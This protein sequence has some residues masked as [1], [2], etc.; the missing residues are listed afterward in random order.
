MFEAAL[1]A[2]AAYQDAAEQPAPR[3][4]HVTF[5]PPFPS[6]DSAGNLKL[7]TANKIV[8]CRFVARHTGVLAK[9]HF[10]VR[11]LIG[12][13]SSYTG[14]TLG[15][16]LCEI[17]RSLPDGQPDMSAAGLLD[18]ESFGPG[19]ARITNYCA[20]MNTDVALRRG[21][22]VFLCVS[23]S[24][25]A[26]ATNYAS[27]N[28]LYQNTSPLPGAQGRNERDPYAEDVYLS[29]DPRELVGGSIDGG[30]TFQLPGNTDAANTLIKH[31]FCHVQEYADGTKDGP[32]YYTA[33]GSSGNA[34]GAWVM[35]YRN[36]TEYWHATH[37]GAWFQATPGS[38]VVE[39]RVNGVTRATATLT[40]AGYGFEAVPLSADVYAK[41]GDTITISVT[42]DHTGAAGA[43]LY[44]VYSRSEWVALLGGA[45]AMDWEATT[46]P[47]AITGAYAGVALPVWLLPGKDAGQLQP[48]DVG[49]ATAPPGSI[50]V[51][52]PEYGATGDG[53]TNDYAAVA[54]AIAKCSADGGGL[55]WFP[56][57]TYLVG[58][59]LVVPTNVRLAGTGKNT[60]VLKKST[61]LTLLTFS[62]SSNSVRCQRG[63]AMDLRLDG[64]GFT[65]PL[66]NA[67]WADHMNF[68]RMWLYN[69]GAVGV[70]F[71]NVWDS[72]FSWSEFDTCSGIDG[73]N[74]SVLL[75]S[76]SDDS[77]NVIGFERCRWENFKDGALWISTAPI[78]SAYTMVTGSNPCYDVRL[79][80]CKMETPQ[81]RGL[82]FATS[83]D[84][85]DVHIDGMYAAARGLYSG[86]TTGRTLFSVIGASDMTF[87]RFRVRIDGV[88]NPSVDDVFTFNTSG[89]GFRLQD[90]FV[91][92][93]QLP[94]TG[95]VS[96]DGGT[97]EVFCE[98][99]RYKTGQ[100]GVIY[101]GSAG[102]IAQ[103]TVASHATAM[104][105]IRGPKVIN[106]S[107]TATITTIPVVPGG[108]EPVTLNFT[109]TASVTDGS[110]LKLNGNFT[111]PGQLTVWGDATNWYEICRDTPPTP[112]VSGFAVYRAAGSG[113]DDTTALN[114]AISALPAAGG[115]ILLP[116]PLYLVTTISIPASPKAVTLIGGGIDTTVIKE[117]T[118]AVTTDVDLIDVHLTGGKLYL[119]DMTLQGPTSV[120]GAHIFNLI[121]QGAGTGGVIDCE[122]VRLYKFGYGIWS[123]NTTVKMRNFVIDGGSAGTALGSSVG[124]Q[125][126]LHAATSLAWLELDRGEITNCGH[127]SSNLYHG[128]YIEPIV[129]SNVSNVRFTNLYGT[130]F[131][132]QHYGPQTPS[133][134]VNYSGCYFGPAITTL[135]G[136]AFSVPPTV[137]CNISDC[138]F[139]VEDNAI[140]S[141]MADCNVRVVRCSF[142]GASGSNQQ[143]T[144][145][146]TGN[147]VLIED[148]EFNGIPPSHVF[149]NADGNVIT[150][151]NTAFGG[152]STN[153]VEFS[154][155]MT[156]TQLF[157]TGNRHTATISGS[158]YKLASGKRASIRDCTFTGSVGSACIN[159]L[160]GSTLNTLNVTDNE[161][162][163]SSGASLTLTAAPTSLHKCG[164][165]GTTGL[166][167]D[168]SYVEGTADVTISATT[169][170]TA[171]TV[172]TA[173]AF[174]ANGSD[175]YVIEFTAAKAEPA[176]TAAASIIFVLYDGASA[177]ANSQIGVVQAYSA[178]GL[179]GVPV[180]LRRRLVP[181][182]AAH[183][184]SVR[185]YRTVGNGVVRAAS[186]TYAPL[187]IRITKQP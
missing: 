156:T 129:N 26:P 161:F 170:A 163:Q 86:I 140:Y 96:W 49:F 109:S 39:V 28:F 151:K 166:S 71:E 88:T 102:N 9:L 72:Y 12:D 23:N 175:A 50:N 144:L 87:R 52:D 89:H 153:D 168:I 186:G 51:Q 29:F 6:G 18:S 83:A 35:T 143:V 75:I 147:R 8:A 33:T 5:N 112:S 74:P 171:N 81:L 1:R 73:F 122:N 136:G 85:A 118:S 98:N 99:V 93:T 138:I 185:A 135:V 36:I 142:L 44:P 11:N 141:G 139:E 148:C 63:G 107:G 162:S 181:S 55:V 90:I 167:S 42:V 37:L 150:V 34:D 97:P 91:D 15:T 155:G 160:S 60:S 30:A 66:I 104:P 146:T 38:D 2:Y 82:M 68:D 92:A 178:T 16:Y 69:N 106:V 40:A 173:A 174:T 115:T 25:A 27:I 95:I 105:V 67:K 101:A 20:Y 164:N 43:N 13:G 54:A 58:T 180:N 152:A 187:A 121:H 137:A 116:D 57:G 119:R 65:G 10:Q 24:D 80:D 124:G 154:T 176:Q 169:E 123:E 111:G 14:G 125:G 120:S 45:G 19:D 110:N 126:I 7:N 145:V 179:G 41:P 61:N 108:R 53:T 183:T 103:P 127:G 17:R 94:N 113:A 157:A 132:T 117:F 22:E 172:A 78:V 77:T 182:A 32:I 64:G 21:E 100:A 134:Y 128:L 46:K 4:R 76:N 3:G 70:K 165:Y 47:A 56:M 79:T 149:C 59:G 130:G 114:A 159:N 62:G 131:H 158:C 177:I 184:Y 48:S 84:V 133:D 31:M